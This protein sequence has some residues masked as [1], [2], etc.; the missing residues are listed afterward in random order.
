MT[1]KEKLVEF[2]NYLFSE[3]RA[4]LLKES[5]NMELNKEIVSDADLENFLAK[6]PEDKEVIEASKLDEV[7]NPIEQLEKLINHYKLEQNPAENI[8]IAIQY[9]EGAKR[10]IERNPTETEV[11]EGQM[12]QV[13]KH[14]EKEEDQLP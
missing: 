13:I 14:L 10:E 8:L 2:G 6:F 1:N 4:N 3:E 9:L 5:V 11:V 7:F 12:S